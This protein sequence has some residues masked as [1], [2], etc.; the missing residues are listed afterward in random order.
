M[1]LHTLLRS[2]AI[3]SLCFSGTTFAQQVMIADTVFDLG[4]DKTVIIEIARQHFHLASV[5]DSD[6]FVVV[7]S[8]D[9]KHTFLGALNFQDGKLIHV[10]KALASFRGTAMSSDIGAALYDALARAGR[11][12]GPMVTM[13]LETTPFTG[14]RTFRTYFRFQGRVVTVLATEQSDADGGNQ[15]SITET[16]FLK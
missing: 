6:D 14:G 11:E 3:T 7:Q 15:M 12:A 1:K 9:P 10:Q 16:V 13:D 5:P 8:N 2:I 4:S